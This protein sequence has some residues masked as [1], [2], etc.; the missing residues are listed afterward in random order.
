MNYFS[1]WLVLINYYVYSFYQRWESDP[2]GYAVQVTGLLLALNILEIIALLTGFDM[3][4]LLPYVYFSLPLLLVVV[5]ANYFLV[6]ANKKHHESFFLIS[7]KDEKALHVDFYKF[8]VYFLLT[9]GP[10]AY[11]FIKKMIAG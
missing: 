7:H 11:L 2:V 8:I 10:F 5:V 6:Y 4:F 3:N 9:V 1:Q